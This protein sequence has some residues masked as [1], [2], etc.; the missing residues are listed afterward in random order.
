MAGL[1]LGTSGWSYTEWKGSFYPEKIR[2]D[3]MLSFYAGRFS[4]VEINNSFYRMPSESV[5]IKW[6]ETAPATFRFAFKAP[7][8]ITHRRRLVDAEGP[9][10]R[11]AEVLATMQ[12]RLGPVL[13][14]LP[15]YQRA[16]L[17]RLER[18][19]EMARPLYARIAFEFRHASWLEQPALDLLTRFD[20]AL[21]STESDTER[22]PV[23]PASNFVY[24]RLRKTE[25]TDGEL[26]AWKAELAKLVDRGLDVFCFFK[27]EGSGKGPEFVRRML[28]D[29]HEH[30]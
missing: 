19:L 10:K 26:T 16:D 12:D 8:E 27:H 11:F 5:L 18:F 22:Q 4:A 29:D 2:P 14:Q 7:Q 3:E 25:Y 17:R 20:A 30:P 13:F 9:T 1:L 15:P 21:C 28:A 6:R 23:H 24:F